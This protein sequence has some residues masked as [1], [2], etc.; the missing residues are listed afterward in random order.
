[1]GYGNRLRTPKNPDFDKPLVEMREL[2][3]RVRADLFVADL[4][5]VLDLL[6]T[7]P[8]KAVAQLLGV[9]FWGGSGSFFDL[10][11][12]REN[13]HVSDDFDLDNR[14]YNGLLL[15][16]LDN[17]KAE[18]FRVSNFEKRRNFLRQQSK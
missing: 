6:R 12:C 11:L 16:V 2:L 7:D 9:D 14:I 1:M 10:L 15:K 3:R 13:G 17:L 4:D 8:E 18:G 5:R